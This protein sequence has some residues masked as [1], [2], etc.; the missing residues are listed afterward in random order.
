[1]YQ[2]Y[3]DGTDMGFGA[4]IANLDK[5]IEFF[6]PLEQ[7]NGHLLMFVKR[8]RCVIMKS[9]HYFDFHIS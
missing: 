8:L 7:L 3:Q 9:I 2:Q 6:F 4:E 5:R 1:M